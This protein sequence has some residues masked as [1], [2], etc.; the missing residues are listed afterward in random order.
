MVSVS[1]TAGAKEDQKDSRAAELPWQGVAGWILLFGLFWEAATKL[2]NKYTCNLT[3]II[4]AW[5]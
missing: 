1:M 2:P 5:P 3:I 4:N